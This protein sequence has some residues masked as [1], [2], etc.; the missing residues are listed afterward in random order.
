MVSTGFLVIT[1]IA[2]LLVFLPFIIFFKH[3]WHSG[4]FG[5][6]FALSLFVIFGLFV[7]IV[8]TD[9][10]VSGFEESAFILYLTWGFTLYL[11]IAGFLGF[12]FVSRLTNDFGH[13]KSDDR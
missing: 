9:P 10:E 5:R 1:F 11:G 6:T 7:W 4:K 2:M 12:K 8:L 13:G 3:C